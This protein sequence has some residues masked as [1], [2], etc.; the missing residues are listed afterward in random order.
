MSSI[1]IFSPSRFSLY[2]ICVT[3]LLWREHIQIKTIFVRNIFNPSRFY[4]EYRRDGFRLIKKIWKKL[5]L[6]DKAYRAANYETISDLMNKEGISY[7]SV[8]ELSNSHCIPV[9]HCNDLNDPVVLQGLKRLTPDLVL[10]TGGGLIRRD[11]LENSGA[12]ILNCHMGVLP[13]YR[14]MDVVEW[15]ILESRLDLLGMT[16]HFMD[17]GIDT[18]DLLRVKKVE[19]KPDET[20]KQIRERLEALMCREMVQTC[21]DTLNGKLKRSPQRREDGR[22]YFIMHPRLIKLAEEKLSQTSRRPK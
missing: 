1:V 17:E 3:E 13:S 7:K 2:T 5:I 9:I 21:I 19:A 12:G 16:V 6:R 4:S 15:P 8:D 14:G 20:I 18:G 22:Q 10:F 11:I